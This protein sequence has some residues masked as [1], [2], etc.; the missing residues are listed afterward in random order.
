MIGKEGPEA[1]TNSNKGKLIEW[2]VQRVKKN[3]IEY[4]ERF[5]LKEVNK[6]KQ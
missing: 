4:L 6:T 5:D 3:G 2:G 1:F